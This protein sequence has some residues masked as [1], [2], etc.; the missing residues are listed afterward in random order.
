MENLGALVRHH[1]KKAKMSRRELALLA[2][3]GQTVIYE[4][5]HGKMTVQLDTLLKI[6][7]AL[8][9]SMHVSGP[10]VTEFNDIT[11]PGSTDEH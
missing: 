4:L 7:R 2:G 1:R 6:M 5:E 10:F 8:N 3:T 9:L 11:S